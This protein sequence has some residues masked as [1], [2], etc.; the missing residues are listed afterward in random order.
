LLKSTK[1]G[2]LPFRLAHGIAGWLGFGYRFAMPF[3]GNP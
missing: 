3:V 1:L 2:N